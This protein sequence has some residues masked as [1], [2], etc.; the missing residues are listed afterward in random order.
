MKILNMVLL[1]VFA[2]GALAAE[3]AVFLED[4]DASW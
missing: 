2:A 4:F 3:K 1:L